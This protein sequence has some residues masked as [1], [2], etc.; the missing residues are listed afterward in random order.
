MRVNVVNARSWPMVGSL[1]LSR[2]TVGEHL[3]YVPEYQLL[4]SYEAGMA[5]IQGGYGYL[6]LHPF[7][8]WTVLIMVHIPH[9]L[10]P[11]GPYTG[12]RAPPCEHPFHCWVLKVVTTSDTLLGRKPGF[13]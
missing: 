4:V 1:L 11:H 9:F 6:S 12:G 10:L 13:C 5:H 2:F 3:S 8:C 7:H